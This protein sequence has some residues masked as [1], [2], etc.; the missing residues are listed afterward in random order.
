MDWERSVERRDLVAVVAVVAGVYDEV[1]WEEGRREPEEPPGLSPGDVPSLRDSSDAG[2]FHF[3]PPE[4]PPPAETDA[5]EV[6]LPLLAR[7]SPTGPPSPP[8]RLRAP[9]RS[10]SDATELARSEYRCERDWDLRRP[11]SAARPP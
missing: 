6:D 1:D 9:T 7:T 3:G 8:P 4:P 11:S 2:L 10:S 5:A